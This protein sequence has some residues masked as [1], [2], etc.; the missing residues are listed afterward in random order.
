MRY[1]PT[2]LYSIA[3]PLVLWSVMDMSISQVPDYLRGTEFM[4]LLSDVISQLLSRVVDTFLAIFL[5]GLF[6]SG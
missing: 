4:T 3:A 2:K 6:A 5:G 1:L